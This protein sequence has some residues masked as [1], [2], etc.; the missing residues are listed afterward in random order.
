MILPSGHHFSFE[1]VL[2]DDIKNALEKETS[3]FN[4]YS[5]ATQTFTAFIECIQ[6]AVS[7]VII[8]AGNDSIP[9]VQMA[10][11]LGW[12]TTVADGRP[13]YARQDRFGSNCQVL[14][15][16]PEHLLDQLTIDRQTVFVLMTHNYNYDLAVLRYLIGKDLAYIGSLG[17]KKKLDRMLNELREQGIEPGSAQVDV[18]Y[19]PSG[20]DIGAETPEEIALSI[21]AEIKSV[22]SGRKGQ[23]LRNLDDAIHRRTVFSRN[24][25]ADNN[26]K[27]AGQ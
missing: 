21:L 6:P 9:L 15:S 25:N 18:I 17:P 19:G 4:Q 20:L 27:M 14:V 23:S 12:E 11:V 2:L 10:Q 8:G 5:S 16:K 13:N 26:I 3:V 7:L 24:A 1:E 22:L